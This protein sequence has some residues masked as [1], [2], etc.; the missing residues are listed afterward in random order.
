MQ[1]LTDTWS[2]TRPNDPG[3]TWPLHL[4]DPIAPSTPTN[5]STSCSGG[6]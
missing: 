2:A 5:G 1:G 6:A 4:E 3:Y